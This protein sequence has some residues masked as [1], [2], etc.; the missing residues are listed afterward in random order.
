MRKLPVTLLAL[1]LNGL[2]AAPASAAAFGLAEWATN[3]GGTVLDNQFVPADPLTTPKSWGWTVSGVGPH[4]ALMFVD[5]E[6]DEATNT[7]FNEYGMTGGSLAAGQSWEIDEPGWVFGDIFPNF[8]IGSLDK[9]NGVDLV[10]FPAG[11]DPTNDPAGDDVSMALGW[12]FTLAAGETASVNF[13]LTD[14]LP[15]S[16]SGF[17]LAQIDP[18]SNAALYFFSTLDIRQGG[19]PT[20]EPAS[21]ALFGIALAGLLAVRGRSA[22]A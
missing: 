4:Q 19:T 9:N 16:F 6:I 17:Y 18:D 14:A 22:K 15:T 7:Y 11:A 2:W 1:M 10:N 20:P 5:P 13:Y 8:A 12:D 3:K 21:L